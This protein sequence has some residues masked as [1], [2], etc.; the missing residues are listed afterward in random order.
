MKQ[1]RWLR[2]GGVMLGVT[3][4]L[5]LLLIAL[6]IFDPKP[7]GDLTTTAVPHT[8]TIPA[9]QQE[10]HWLP[11]PLPPGNFTMR[12]TVAHQSGELDSGAG[13]VLSGECGYLTIAVSPLGYATIYDTPLHTTHC[14]LL[15]EIPWQPWPH[16]KTGSEPDELWLDFADGQ[17]RIR[18][19]RELLWTGDAPFQPVQMGLYGESW[20]DTAVF[21]FQKIELFTDTD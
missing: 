21:H 8:L 15:T 12:A 11:E 14:S 17:M 16:V 2:F 1:M 9:K 10:I 7:V 20:G 18:I 4:V 13:L 5:L 6:G 3:A 19:N